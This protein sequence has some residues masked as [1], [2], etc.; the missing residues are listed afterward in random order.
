MNKENPT[1]FCFKSLILEGENTYCLLLDNLIIEKY[2]KSDHVRR[3]ALDKAK[4][5]IKRIIA[6]NKINSAV[7]KITK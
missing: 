5:S 4:D 6:Y 2:A 1:N 3:A 7:V